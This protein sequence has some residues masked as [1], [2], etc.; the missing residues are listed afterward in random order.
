[1]VRRPPASADGRADRANY[2]YTPRASPGPPQACSWALFFLGFTGF[3]CSRCRNW[4]MVNSPETS[5][6]LRGFL[7]SFF[8]AFAWTHT[9]RTIKHPF[10][11]LTPD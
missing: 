1:M 4:T 9:S 10:Q 11:W 5:Q 3:N 8:H 6:L 2:T 7:L